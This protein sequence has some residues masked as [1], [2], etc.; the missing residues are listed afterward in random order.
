MVQE[1]KV[2]VVADQLDKKKLYVKWDITSDQ[3]KATF[4]KFGAVSDARVVPTGRMSDT[5]THAGGG[6]AWEMERL[7]IGC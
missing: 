2:S 1:Q 4:G 3:L 5:S 6:R 7:P